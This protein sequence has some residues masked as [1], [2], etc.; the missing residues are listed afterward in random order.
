MKIG[1][2]HKE[3]DYFNMAKV[4]MKKSVNWNISRKE[5]KLTANFTPSQS[6]SMK[7]NPKKEEAR[8][9]S[10]IS[11]NSST[12]RL[13][14]DTESNNSLCLSIDN[15]ESCYKRKVWMQETYGSRQIRKKVDIDQKLFTKSQSK[16]NS[17]MNIW[18]LNSKGN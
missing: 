12:I 15:R 5:T 10:D 1:L 4:M 2:Q 14:S 11:N 6:N 8:K 13:L 9:M 3:G 16:S 7:S 18:F 17:S